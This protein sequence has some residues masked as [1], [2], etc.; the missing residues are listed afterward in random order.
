MTKMDITKLFMSSLNQKVS[1]GFSSTATSAMTTPKTPKITEAI[2]K[3]RVAIFCIFIPLAVPLMT[4][5][6][7]IYHTIYRFSI[8]IH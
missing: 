5:T 6:S 8:N 1:P 3:T 4:V 2:M 7:Q